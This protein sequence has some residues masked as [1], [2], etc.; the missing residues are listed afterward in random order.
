[1]ST[2]SSLTTSSITT[3]VELKAPFPNIGTPASLCILSYL[4]YFELSRF[5]AAS[6]GANNLRDSNNFQLERAIF[7]TIR[8]FDRAQWKEYYNAK[9]TSQYDAR[10][11]DQRVLRAFLKAYYG[12]DPMGRGRVCDNCLIPTV[13]P[14]RL[15]R[16]RHTYNFYENNSLSLLGKLAE[17]PLKGYAAKYLKDQT[18][19]LQQNG[20]TPAG[21]SRLVILLK[22]VIARNKPWSK[23]SQNPDKRGQVQILR[24]MFDRTR[25]GCLPNAIS[26][27]TVIFAHHAISGQRPM[28]DKTGIE[29]CWT[30]GRTVE[31][32]RYDGQDVTHM[33][34]GGFRAFFPAGGPPPVGLDVSGSL[35][36]AE[37]IGVPLLREF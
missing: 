6:K 35:V 36:A 15:M 4:E 19:S 9:V 34:S 14:S 23:E 3:S 20:M 2:I 30:F 17:H 1:M 16:I 5:S 31:L 12:P 18:P 32:V 22:G 8:I 25:W 13:V 7:S 26:Q 37:N 27:N 29:G 33:I 11:I 24:E 10:K 21:A 28:G